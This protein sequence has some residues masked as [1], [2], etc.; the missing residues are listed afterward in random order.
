[1][2]YLREYGLSKGLDKAVFCPAFCFH[3]L[4][5]SL[6][7]GIKNNTEITDAQFDDNILK[8]NY[9][10]KINVCFWVSHAYQLKELFKSL[11]H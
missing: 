9:M 7:A 1:M 10:Q 8:Y 11:V 6:A 3:P 4:V 2:V 5:E